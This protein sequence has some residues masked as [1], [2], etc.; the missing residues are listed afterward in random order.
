MFF[1]SAD[2]HQQ[3]QRVKEQKKAK[4]HNSTNAL[5]KNAQFWDNAYDHSRTPG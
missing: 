3:P 4:K 5:N 2:Q 1:V